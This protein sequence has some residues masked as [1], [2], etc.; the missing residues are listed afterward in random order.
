MRQY[1]HTLS[2]KPTKFPLCHVHIMLWK[3]LATQVCVHNSC[4]PPATTLCTYFPST[5][6]LDCSV[7]SFATNRFTPALGHTTESQLNQLFQQAGQQHY[8]GTIRTW[9]LQIRLKGSDNRH[10]KR[11]K[12]VHTYTAV[13]KA[14]V[15]SEY[16][17]EGWH[18][19]IE[20]YL[21]TYIK[22]YAG[23]HTHWAAVV[24]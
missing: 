16:C 10:Q 3:F 21:R 1:C 5:L 17:D 20:L 9:H 22:V 23:L 12:P 6:S 11:V 19:W 24:W 15:I 8:T 13:F 7:F 4:S 2:G 18:K 14:A